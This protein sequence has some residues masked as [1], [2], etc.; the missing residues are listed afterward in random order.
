MYSYRSQSYVP[1]FS[2][3]E[4]GQ[5]GNFLYLVDAGQLLIALLDMSPLEFRFFLIRYI[6]KCLG[7]PALL[8]VLQHLHNRTLR[9]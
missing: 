3:F 9:Q 4:S 6:I 1:I 2:K 5:L 7:A 8:R